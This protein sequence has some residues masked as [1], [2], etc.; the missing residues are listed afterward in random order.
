[1]VWYLASHR[2]L[3]VF[4]PRSR[5]CGVSVAA[6]RL[7]TMRILL[8]VVDIKR[9]RPRDAG[10]ERW[11]TFCGLCRFAADLNPIDDNE[12]PMMRNRANRKT[13]GRPTSVHPSRHHCRTVAAAIQIGLKTASS[14]EANLPAHS[15][16]R[17]RMPASVFFNNGSDADS[18]A[19]QLAKCLLIPFVKNVNAGLFR[20]W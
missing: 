7:G 19:A 15:Q 1:M 9:A 18:T 17:R 12:I 8:T 20:F 4:N 10:T 14:R 13:L 3:C 2:Y 6:K 11:P 16:P 5:V